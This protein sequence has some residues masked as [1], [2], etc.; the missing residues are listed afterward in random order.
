M[1]KIFVFILLGIS[2]A[3]CQE[4][5]FTRKEAT[6]CLM[7]Y[8]DKNSDGKVA[9]TE[10]RYF[11]NKY[12]SEQERTLLNPMEDVFTRCDANGNFMITRDELE[13]SQNMCLASCDTITRFMEYICI[14]AIQEHVDR[15]GRA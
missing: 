15:T 9:Y 13:H 12:L 8:V 11:R 5:N 14:H 4:C 7:D 2:F 10:L 3:T 6:D 1:I